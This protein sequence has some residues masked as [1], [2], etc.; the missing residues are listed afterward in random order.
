MKAT[1]VR[2]SPP[3]NDALPRSRPTLL[4]PELVKG[5]NPFVP[6]AGLSW[7][8][9][10]IEDCTVIVMFSCAVP[11][12]PWPAAVRDHKQLHATSRL[13]HTPILSFMF[14]FIGL[15]FFGALKT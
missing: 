10:L 3:V 2:L 15:L 7:N 11:V 13:L 1:H 14:I 4:V 5:Q 9:R 8:T 6:T 12:C